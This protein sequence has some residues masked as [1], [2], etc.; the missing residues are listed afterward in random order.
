MKSGRLI[1]FV[2]LTGACTS[3]SPADFL[4]L[5]ADATIETSA[6]RRA[7]RDGSADVAFR[8]SVADRSQIEQVTNSFSTHF[9]KSGWQPRD[10][11]WMNPGLETSFVEGWKHVCGCVLLTDAQGKALTPPETFTWH[12][13][14]Q[15]EHGDVT[16][17]HLIASDGH[18]RGSAEYVP[19]KLVTYRL[20][21]IRSP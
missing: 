21:P 5:P 15:D 11:Q 2:L 7:Y 16:A 1:A 6:P 8:I 20:A 9:E 3:A 19:E 4:W 13:E 10:H 12:G 18:V 17:Y 14:W